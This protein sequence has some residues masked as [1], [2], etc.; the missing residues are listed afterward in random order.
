MATPDRQEDEERNGC[1]VHVRST[2]QKMLWTPSPPPLVNGLDSVVPGASGSERTKNQQNCQPK[3][4][5]QSRATMKA[6]YNRGSG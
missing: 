6:S 2:E 4:L 5:A 1:S 3:S